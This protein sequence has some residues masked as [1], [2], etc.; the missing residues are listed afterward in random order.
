MPSQH[1]IEAIECSI[2]ASHSKKTA[3]EYKKMPSHDAIMPSH[4]QIMATP[5][6]IMGFDSA[7]TPANNE[8]KKT[9][10]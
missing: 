6:A 2:M 10:G 1:Q 7:I 5:F 3:I 4:N 8:K 9:I